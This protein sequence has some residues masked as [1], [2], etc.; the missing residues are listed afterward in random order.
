MNKS[1]LGWRPFAVSVEVCAFATVSVGRKKTPTPQI[2]LKNANEACN[3]TATPNFKTHEV[4]RETGLVVLTLSAFHRSQRLLQLAHD[5]SGVLQWRVCGRLRHLS[6]D[7][8]ERRPGGGAEEAG[9]PLCS[10]GCRERVQVMDGYKRD[11]ADSSKGAFIR[12]NP[13]P[14][15][16]PPH[17]HTHSVPE[18]KGVKNTGHRVHSGINRLGYCT[19]GI[20]ALFFPAQLRAPWL[21]WWERTPKQKLRAKWKL[22]RAER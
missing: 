11:A 4:F 16:P 15:P 8:P 22:H 21:P 2:F 14:L 5:P 6:A 7:A 10:A 3:Q 12:L 1:E 20:T 18:L 19:F 13:S 17:K 9:H